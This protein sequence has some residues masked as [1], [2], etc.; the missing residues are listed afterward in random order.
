MANLNIQSTSL[1][2]FV[3]SWSSSSSS[4]NIFARVCPYVY[5]IYIYG[6][7]IDIRIKPNSSRSPFLISLY[8]LY[9]PVKD[10]FSLLNLSQQILMDFSNTCRQYFFKSHFLIQ[11]SGVSWFLTPM[12]NARSG[13]RFKRVKRSCSFTPAPP[14]NIQVFSS[15]DQDQ[16]RFE[17]LDVVV[18]AS[19]KTTRRCCGSD[20][21]ECS[22]RHLAAD[23]VLCYGKQLNAHDENF[24]FIYIMPFG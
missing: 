15:L 17:V 3:S 20:F 1:V 5:Y 19:S 24:V 13:K 8:S 21:D 14:E 4:N 2:V 11:G 18:L 22:F 23:V 10:A 12:Q 9:D 6:A 7:V 16:G